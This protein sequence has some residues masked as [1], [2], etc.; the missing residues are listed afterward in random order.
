[1]CQ[2]ESHCLTSCHIKN[3]IHITLM[4]ELLYAT[5]PV[6]FVRCIL[7]LWRGG[8][9]KCNFLFSVYKKVPSVFQ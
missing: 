1:M 4:I 7:H 2:E 6:V 8:R 5:I 9:E 3:Y